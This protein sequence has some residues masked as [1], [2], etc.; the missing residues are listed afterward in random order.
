MHPDDFIFKNASPGRRAPRLTLRW[1]GTAGYELHSGDHSILID[2][3]LTR[4]SLWSFVRGPLVA[5]AARIDASIQ[6]VDAIFVGHSHFDH[7]LDVPH[8]AKKTGASVYGSEST[9][10]LLAAAGVLADQIVRC[11][12]REIVEVGPFRVT[13]IP[14]VHSRLGLGKKV[15]FAGDIPC[16]CELPLR[17][18]EYRC[19]QVFGFLIEVHGFYLYHLGSA[20]LIDDEMP[21]RE[22]DLLLLCIAGR[23]NTGNFV[24]RVLRRLDPRQLMPMHYDNFFRAAD[25]PLALLPL[26]RFGR[27]C[28]QVNS[29]NGA[30]EIRTLTLNGSVSFM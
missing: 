5:D 1:L 13:V 22:L 19:V 17:G 15:P 12:G 21:K 10:N 20:D 9:A 14:S 4:A 30:V 25:A 26:V 7:V 24:G 2:P 16:S 27:F 28:E 3:Y 6:G 11:S 18:R 29:V 23:H 8:L